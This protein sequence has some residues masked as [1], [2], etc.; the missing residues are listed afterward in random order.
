MGL[1]KKF[2]TLERSEGSN[3]QSRRF[4]TSFRMT[5]FYFLDGLKR[6]KNSGSPRLPLFFGENKLCE[7]SEIITKIRLEIIVLSRI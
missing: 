5:F 4:F 2:V 3:R 1:F 6:P 7:F